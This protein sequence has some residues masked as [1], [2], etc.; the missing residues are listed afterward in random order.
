MLE[1][2][3]GKTGAKRQ[4][5]QRANPR[6]VLKRLK[7]KNQDWTEE[8]LQAECWRIIS[9]DKEQLYTVFE[10]WFANNYRSLLYPLP[11]RDARSSGRGQTSA[12]IHDRLADHI[13]TKVNEQVDEK[14]QIILLDML[15]PNGK[16]LR[17][18][19]R[20]ELVECGGWLQK[21]AEKLKPNQTVGQ[22]GISEQKLRELYTAP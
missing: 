12:A 5:W 17:A 20:E 1:I 6:D 2:N 21:V 11:Q 7:D 22:A 15:L 8:E 16:P 9:G 10:Y 13:N 4:S 3:T 18:A 19:T 14:I